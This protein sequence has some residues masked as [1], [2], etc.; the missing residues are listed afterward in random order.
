MQYRS[1]WMQEE[2]DLHGGRHSGRVKYSLE[3]ARQELKGSSVF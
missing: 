1:S 3:N 2:V